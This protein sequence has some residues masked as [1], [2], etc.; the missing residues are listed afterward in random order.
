MS[1]LLIVGI[2]IFVVGLLQ[3]PL[4]VDLIRSF[5]PSAIPKRLAGH[6]IDA[7]IVTLMT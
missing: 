6:M 7:V 5:K 3:L 2:I 4:L 1:L